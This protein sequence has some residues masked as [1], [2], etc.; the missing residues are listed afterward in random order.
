MLLLS[1]RQQWHYSAELEMR[2]WVWDLG[3]GL[4]E[5]GQM[6]YRCLEDAEAAGLGLLKRSRVVWI[7]GLGQNW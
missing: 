7:K 1:S 4:S 6:W 3:F 5:H 2:H